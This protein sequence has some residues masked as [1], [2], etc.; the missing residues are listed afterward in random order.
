LVRGRVDNRW[1][2]EGD[3]GSAAGESEQ[4]GALDE[5]LAERAFT[6]VYQPILNLGTGA[7]VG[8][9]VLCRFDDGTSPVRRFRDAERLGLAAKLDIAIIEAALADLP[10][11][12]PGY[13]SI[14]LSPSTLRDPSLGDVLLRSGVPADRVVVEVTENARILDYD[15]AQTLLARIRNSGVRLAVDDAGAGY[16]TLRHMLAL[17]PDF[18]KM[19]RALTEDVDSDTA[20]HVLATALVTFAGE[21]GASVIAEGVET[22]GEIRGVRRAGIEH[23]QGYA[24]GRPTALPSA[25]NGYEPEVLT[26]EIVRRLDEGRRSRPT[27][28]ARRQPSNR[29]LM[30]PA[31]Q[32][33]AA[34][35]GGRER[36]RRK[37]EESNHA[38][39]S[40]Q[41]DLEDTVVL[42]RKAGMSWD[43][44]ATI[45]GMSRQGA[46][47]R[48]GQGRLH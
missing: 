28:D 16:A 17:Q 31:G 8:V 21:I 14:N 45:L 29:A 20:R 25:P 6:L 2:R 37:L 4:R 7:V 27:V 46:S 5:C 3:V 43:E 30:R 12:D 33:S 19:D 44:I 47:K 9:E 38:A 11:V 39:Q 22:M 41:S 34:E 24:L 23:A 18:I 36:A 10:D 48:F 35:T 26:D 13:V 40:A 15:A 42:G 1:V 32:P